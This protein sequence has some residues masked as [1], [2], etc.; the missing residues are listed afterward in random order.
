MKNIDMVVIETKSSYTLDC[1]SDARRTVM[2]K[3]MT[4]TK[5]TSQ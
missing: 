5:I 2:A 1:V 4:C 3:F